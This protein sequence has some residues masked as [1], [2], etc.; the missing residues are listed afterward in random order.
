MSLMRC[1]TFCD[2]K[3]YGLGLEGILLNYWGLVDWGC[4]SRSVQTLKMLDR[5]QQFSVGVFFA[6]SW[7][8]YVEFILFELLV[9][10]KV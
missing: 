6:D 1:G 5:L 3:K 10:T 9:R 7:E 2:Q 8:A 4:G